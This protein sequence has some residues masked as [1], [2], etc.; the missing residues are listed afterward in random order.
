MR[1][2]KYHVVGNAMIAFRDIDYMAKCESRMSSD[3]GNCRYH[4]ANRGNVTVHMCLYFDL[5]IHFSLM[6]YLSIQ[7]LHSGN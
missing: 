2:L 3:K 6:S 5:A 1:A 7:V 4:L